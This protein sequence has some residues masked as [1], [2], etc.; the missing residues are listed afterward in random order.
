MITLLVADDHPVIVDGIQTIIKSCKEIQLVRDFAS[1]RQLLDY[2]GNHK[3][4]VVL[5]DINMPDINGIEACKEIYK[6]HPQIKVLAFS[7][8]DDKNFVKRMMKNGAS[9]YLLKNSGS[10]EI[11]DAVKRVHAGDIFLSKSLSNIFGVSKK[12]KSSNIL[13]PNI[14]KRELDV[15][16]LIL[17]ENSTQEISDILFISPHTVESHRA[18]LLLKTGAKNTAGLVRWA[19]ENDVV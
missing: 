8:Y 11:I 15:L 17:D 14:S 16:R 12:K 9:G 5:L 19:I 3:A 4:D 10:Q 13:F 18:H 7:Q 2:L 6:N 1:G